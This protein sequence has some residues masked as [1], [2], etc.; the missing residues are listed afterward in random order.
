MNTTPTPTPEAIEAAAR[1]MF[2]QQVGLKPPYPLWDDADAVEKDNCRNDAQ[3]ALS[4]AYPL[5]E[6]ELLLDTPIDYSNVPP[7]STG[8]IERE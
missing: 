5:M 8:N 1:A 3:L 7:V 4:A 6:A 2:Y